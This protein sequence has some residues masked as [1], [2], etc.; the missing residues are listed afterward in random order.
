MSPIAI[1]AYLTYGLAMNLAS[2]GLS[3]VAAVAFL[4]GFRFLYRGRKGG[5]Q[6]TRAT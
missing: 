3:L 4:S 6:S 2:L 5:T 1:D